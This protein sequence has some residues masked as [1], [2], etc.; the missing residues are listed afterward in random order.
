MKF[1]RITQNPA[2][3]GLGPPASGGRESAVSA[4][5]EIVDAFPHSGKQGADAPRSRNDRAA[6]TERGEFSYRL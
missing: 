5:A 1:N 6:P 3:M 2:V 4:P